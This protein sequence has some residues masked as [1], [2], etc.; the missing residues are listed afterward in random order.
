MRSELSGW[1][2]VK[3]QGMLKEAPA[4]DTTVTRMMRMTVT[5]NKMSFCFMAWRIRS[6]TI[7]KYVNIRKN[8]FLFNYFG[9]FFHI[10]HF[11]H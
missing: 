7:L 10:S 6:F 5:A 11:T 1:M 4:Q 3:L 9:Q 2:T 8:I